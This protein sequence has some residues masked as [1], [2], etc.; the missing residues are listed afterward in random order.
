[1]N[2]FSIEVNDNNLY[3]RF[4]DDSVDKS[5]EVSTNPIIIVD[6]NYKG[7]VIGVEILPLK[8]N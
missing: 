2:D 7:D 5:K 4:L 6:F 3:I 1:M 8:K